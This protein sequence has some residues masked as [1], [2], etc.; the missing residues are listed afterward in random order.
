MNILISIKKA[1]A[2]RN[3]IENQSFFLPDDFLEGHGTKTIQD[4]LDAV[5]E[6]CVAQYKK[7]KDSTILKLLTK[8]EIEDKACEGKV[9]FDINYGE[10]SPSL[11]QAKHNT[12]QCYLDGLFALFIDEKE[13]CGLQSSAPLETPVCLHENS[14]VIFI[15]LTM[16]A[17][18]MY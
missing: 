14:S 4:F 5:T 7:R 13:I 8:K 9:A 6:E 3:S 18:R 10:K 16:L 11:E 17:G 15:K 1:G 12:R 2:R